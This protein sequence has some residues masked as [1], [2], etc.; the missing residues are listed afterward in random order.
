MRMILPDSDHAHA[1]ALPSFWSAHHELLGF[2][3]A[4]KLALGHDTRAMPRAS[5]I[6]GTRTAATLALAVGIGVLGASCTDGDAP[7]APSVLEGGAPIDDAD[8]DASL[9][10]CEGRTDK[11]SSFELG[12][13]AIGLSRL[14]SSRLVAA[15]PAPPERYL[16]DWTLDFFDDEGTP[17]ED[18]QITM[19]RS[20]MPTHGHDGTFA[21]TVT[22]L[23]EPGRFEVAKLNLW[24]R[25]PWLV[26]L[27]VSSPQVGDD[28]IEFS[29]CIDD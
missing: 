16:N 14:V 2:V 27:N 11:A 22:K 15:D 7:V 13:E 28:Y 3:V 5:M 24:M 29:V 1:D 18:I 21:P 17:I 4:S 19:A 8:V 23:S 20:F 9:A 26:Q 25:G 6:H 10:P 12:T